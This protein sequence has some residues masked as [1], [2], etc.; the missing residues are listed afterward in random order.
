MASILNSKLSDTTKLTAKMFFIKKAEL[1]S[2]KSYVDMFFR[3]RLHFFANE[4]N[5][6]QENKLRFILMNFNI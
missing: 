3:K 6:H 5:G 4:I 2:I 1:T